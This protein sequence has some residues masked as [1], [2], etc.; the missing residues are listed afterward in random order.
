[1]A[2][3][4]GQQHRHFLTE[5]L[6]NLSRV[7]NVEISIACLEHLSIPR[8]GDR[9]LAQPAALQVQHTA[10]FLMRCFLETVYASL[11]HSIDLYITRASLMICLT[12]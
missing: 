5:L 3:V 10:I 9:V 2:N 6:H 4:I 11:N 8:S 12:L 1:M 7:V